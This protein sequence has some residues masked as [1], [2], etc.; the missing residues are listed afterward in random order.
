[1]DGWMDGWMNGRTD[2]LMYGKGMNRI[3]SRYCTVLLKTN[4][5]HQK[6]VQ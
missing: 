2:G 4:T 5:Y 6:Q 1:M 3:Y